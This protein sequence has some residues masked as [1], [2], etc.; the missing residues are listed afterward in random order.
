MLFAGLLLAGAALEAAPAQAN[1]ADRYRVIEGTASPDGRYA[2][3]LGLDAPKVDWKAF[4]DAESG[5]YLLDSS[6]PESE[7]R[8]YL[9]E[10]GTRRILAAT[11]G[12]Y[13]YSKPRITH[14]ACGVQWS[15]DS[16]VFVQAV[17]RGWIGFCLA[18]R[19]QNGRLKTGPL[20]I[21]SKAAGF[22]WTF[23]AQRKNAAFLKHGHDLAILFSLASV[24]NDGVM[25]LQLDGAVPHL[26]EDD[27]NFEITETLQLGK[28]GAVKLLKVAYHKDD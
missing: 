8:N 7:I 18:G 14:L 15:P 22:A 16:Q 10:V 25:V 26:G 27:S 20:D 2:I 1:D 17:Q 19:V 6:L 28:D 9:V 11:G 5:A 3:A 24:R 13:I 4:Y 23:L 21:G 12:H